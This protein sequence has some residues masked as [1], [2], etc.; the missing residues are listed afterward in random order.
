MRDKEL[1][2]EVLRLIE[3]AATKI[4]DRFQAIHERVS[5]MSLSTHN[6]NHR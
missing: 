1:T 6:L 3:E 2:L 4:V 5:L